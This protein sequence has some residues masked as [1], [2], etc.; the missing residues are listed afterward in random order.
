MRRARPLGVPDIIGTRC[1][2][3][4]VRGWAAFGAWRH[5]ITRWSGE[6][7]GE[8]G[9]GERVKEAGRE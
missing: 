1:N 8:G 5:E 4:V 2:E 6:A 9:G 3:F 7:K